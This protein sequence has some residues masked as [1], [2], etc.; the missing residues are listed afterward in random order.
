MWWLSAQ[1]W[2][3]CTA[4]STCYLLLGCLATWSCTKYNK[5]E[6]RSKFV[7]KIWWSKLL[8]KAAVV[9][10]SGL[11]SLHCYLAVYKIKNCFAT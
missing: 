5:K 3:T 9:N 8:L 6:K 10:C 2:A 1:G 4:T 7:K 11:G